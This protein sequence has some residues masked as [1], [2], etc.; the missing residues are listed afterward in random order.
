V[1]W[2]DL[3]NSMRWPNRKTFN[4]ERDGPSSGLKLADLQVSFDRFATLMH[5]A[6][7]DRSAIG[8]PANV[9]PPSIEFKHNGLASVVHDRGEWVRQ[10]GHRFEYQWLRD[11]CLRRRARGERDE[12]GHPQRQALRASSPFPPSRNPVRAEH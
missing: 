4:W 6:V 5:H 11:G 2:V 10:Q 9:S 7:L 12:D 3:F 8:A 1:P